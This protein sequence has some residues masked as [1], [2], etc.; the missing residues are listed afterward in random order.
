MA[1][2]AP[3]DASSKQDDPLCLKDTRTEVLKQ[4][5]AWTYGEERS[6]IFWLNGMAGTGESTIAR[7]IS[8]EFSNRGDLGASFFFARGGGDVG[9][10]GM[11]FTSIAKQ[12]AIARPSV[13]QI[14]SESVQAQPD[15]ASKSRNDQWTKLIAQPLGMIQADP[16]HPMLV[17]VV[18]AL[19]ECDNDNDMKGIIAA[20]AR[21]QD[22]VSVKLR[23]IVTS[24][25]ETPI[26]LGF[27]KMPEIL[28]LD[29]L[30]HD[31]PREVVDADICLFLYSEFEE[32]KEIH[33]LPDDW[34]SVD[35]VN[36]LVHLSAGLFIFAATVCR[37]IHEYEQ[38]AEDSLKLFLPGNDRDLATACDDLD[39]VTGETTLF[40]DS[41]YSQILERS[42]PS[43]TYKVAQP[44][45]FRETLGAIVAL[46]EPLPI[47]A[48]ARLLCLQESDIHQRLSRLHSVIRVP[49]AS[50]SSIRL[51]HAS[52]RDYL[53]DRRRCGNPAFLVH[54]EEAHRRL[55]QQCIHAMESAL[56]R[57]M[58]DLQHPGV[59]VSEV[60]QSSIDVNIPLHVQYACRH[61]LD[62]SDS[63]R[64]SLA[65]NGDVHQFL[66]RYSLYWL[67][68]RAL[69]AKYRRR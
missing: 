13:K 37:F 33:G 14:I 28:H 15:I 32:T 41:M 42:G 5:R 46:S 64:V 47:G 65:D 8:R 53:F 17:I 6:C 48:L 68:V 9:H 56:H 21:A 10:A 11:F 27:K 1:A 51:F 69:S 52:F 40:L 45:P 63:G 34:P 61:W 39:E 25:P 19:D 12:L 55:L 31:Q 49:M 22:V 54:K 30:L 50:D 23:I 43:T 29:L 7:T 36:Q 4:I 60:T 20:L 58:C 3:F 62:H 24:R 66:R 44:S 16:Q 59:L 2:Q 18:D 38:S 57:D 35:V 67:E 26:R